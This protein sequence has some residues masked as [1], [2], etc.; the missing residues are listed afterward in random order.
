MRLTRREALKLMAAT[1]IASTV[2]GTALIHK[3]RPRVLLE[4][5]KTAE[6][7]LRIA[8][9]ACLICGQ[10]CP[11]KV[12]VKRVGGRDV[13]VRVVHNTDVAHD[14]YFGTCG[15]PQL[16]FELPYLEER[17]KKPLIRVGKRGEGRFREITWDEALNILAEK[18]K[19]YLN[20]PWRI[21]VV[22]HQGCEA[23]IVRSTI[24]K[25]TGTPN[26][27]MHCDTC[28]TGMD[29][30]HR[31]LFG[32]PKG[33]SA[34]QPDYVNAKLVV[35]IGRNPVGGVVASAWTKM[36]TEARASKTKII[37]FDVRESRLTEQADEY[38]IVPPGT[39]LAIS[40]AILNVLLTEKLYNKEYLVKWTNAPM[41]VYADT[42]EPVKLLDNPYLKGKK[43]YLVYDEVTKKYV[44]KTEAL[45]PSVDYEGNLNNRAVKT[46]LMV[47]RDAVAKYTPEWAEKITGVPA[48]TIKRVAHELANAA[49]KAFIDHG[50]KGA[51]YYNEGMLKRVNMLINALLGSI[52]SVGGLAYPAGK[53]HFKDPFSILGLKP[54]KKQGKAIYE[55]W[56]E[57]GVVKNP[58][59]KCWSQLL[60]RS[61]IEGKPYPIGVLI[62]DRENLVS[63]A[64][65][66]R[67]LAEALRDENR[68]E[69]IVVMDT[70]FNET[71]MYADLVLPVPYFFEYESITLSFAKKS[72]VSIVTDLQKVVDPPPGVDAKPEWW[73]LVELLKR[74]GKL[75]QSLEPDPVKIKAEQAQSAGLDYAKIRKQGY[76]LLWTKPKYHPW[77]GK[78]LPTASGEIEVLNIA[79][80]EKY[81][82][83]LGKESPLNP[84]P[85]WIPPLW[86]K[87]TNGELGDNEFI[88]IE[89][90]DS[91]TAV[92]TFVRFSRL[93]T[94]ALEWRRVYGVQ[95][96]PERAKRL[97][98][99]DGDYVKV[100]GP[101]G[102]VVAKAIVTDRVHPYVLAA[103]HATALDEA[104][105]PRRVSIETKNGVVTVKLFSNGGGYGMNNNF[106]AD[107]FKSVVPEEGYRAAQ[108]DFVARVEKIATRG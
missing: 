16:I 68:V 12:Y 105:I 67:K 101:N 35:L 103:P 46:A 73:I 40:L 100:K 3:H 79:F 29:N 84:L 83:Y 48:S 77:G 69:F 5:G 91:V 94:N 86:M 93:V 108:H 23:G 45:S 20:E 76:A 27:T 75:P 31:W 65:G 50:Y 85:V 32:A 95:I 8:Y 41:L 104:I 19:N 61:I 14:Q 89:F 64:I 97:G 71:T 17:I 88:V 55:Y 7:T 2:S 6:S 21:V 52:G 72:Y 15:R 42:L 98:I 87:E 34:F 90:Q 66:G 24:S 33:P 62:I 99:R 57:Q 102:E 60:V 54:V 38:Y 59:S 37:V 56:E 43:T 18:L 106:L 92:N 58:I 26:T 4:P 51:R 44:P 13:P 49:P 96:H 70:T 36:F 80:L 25:A 82:D 63:H 53:P 1:A 28:H 81:R 107:P 9:S 10:R 30:G 78:P 39:D 74:L 47:L 11:L 22:A